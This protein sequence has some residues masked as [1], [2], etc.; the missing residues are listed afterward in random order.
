MK[1]S[2][3]EEIRR[4]LIF[5]RKPMHVED[6]RQLVFDNRIYLRINDS[7]RQSISTFKRV[8]RDMPDV[9]VV[10]DNKTKTWKRR[11]KSRTREEY[12]IELKKR[13]KQWLKALGCRIESLIKG[14][15]PRQKS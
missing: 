2:L 14:L 13:V 9:V 12:L 7:K 5:T 10:Y 11:L 1:M 8:M 15:Y 3:T 4:I 6:I